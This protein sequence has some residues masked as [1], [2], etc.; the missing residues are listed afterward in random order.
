MPNIEP[1]NSFHLV[2]GTPRWDDSTAYENVKAMSPIQT[3]WEFFRRLPET[4]AAWMESQKQ[5]TD[6]KR[7]RRLRNPT[8]PLSAGQEIFLDWK[9]AGGLLALAMSPPPLEAFM[10]R[11]TDL[12]N[13][14][15]I[16]AHIGRQC[17]DLIEGGLVMFVVDPN[18]S[19]SKQANK[20]KRTI[21]EMQKQE[22]RDVKQDGA[23]E[24]AVARPRRSI[25]SSLRPELLL[26]FLDAYD[27]NGIRPG[28]SRRV[29]KTSIAKK[30]FPEDFECT[31]WNKY[32]DSAYKQAINWPLRPEPEPRQSFSHKSAVLRRT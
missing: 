22:V 17:L 15:K 28:S 19:A 8:L 21:E 9:F 7:H 14:A 26:R 31:A 23:G 6:G 4:R 1:L 2:W 27:Q 20:I 32:A 25:S 5:P 12:P 24:G 10:R 30:I 13:E 11:P 16:A 3:R 18:Q 29:T